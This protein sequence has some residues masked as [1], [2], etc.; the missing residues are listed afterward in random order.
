M[1]VYL[2]ERTERQTSHQGTGQ[3]WRKI[4]T[5]T[6]A[7]VET[8]VMLIARVDCEAG[9]GLLEADSPVFHSEEANTETQKQ[10]ILNMTYILEEWF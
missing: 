8:A 10:T 7:L 4:I 3:E 1:D 5:I 9:S 6:E 2:E